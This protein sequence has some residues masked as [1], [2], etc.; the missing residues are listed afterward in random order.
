MGLFKRAHVR[1][2]VHEATLQGL[3]SWPSKQAEEE[4]ADALADALEDEEMPEVTDEE[5]LTEEEAAEV[6]E[7]IVEVANAIEEKTGG[8]ILE[9]TQKIAA[10]M[11]YHSAASNAALSVMEKAAE[12]TAVATGPDVPG[13]STPSPDNSA[14][15]EGEIDEVKNP[16]S[17]VVVPVGTSSVDTSAGAVG[18]EEPQVQ[19]PGAVGTPANSEAS[20]LSHIL[21]A[22]N[23]HA[24]AKADGASLSG[25]SA[26]GPAPTPRKDVDD[27]L[28][29]PGV[30]APG[31]GKSQQ[32]IPRGANEGMLM[33]QPAGTPGPTDR[34]DNELEKDPIKKA[35]A[36][37]RST[38]GGRNVLYK[39]SE[40][41]K[42]AEQEDIAAQEARAAQALLN[43]AENL[44]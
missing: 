38:Q 42:V 37:L 1:G 9:D 44:R 33:R 39:L 21:S 35:A 23:K 7:Q 10:S 11:D 15:A 41:A 2:M 36:M 28:G 12:E 25:G 34:P 3:V 27:N 26:G 20:K 17:D 22:L 5:G 13:T 32:S 40:A 8:A 30:I 18:A 31:Q 16:S 6:L 43:M 19:E 29:I 24:A 4:A 14:T